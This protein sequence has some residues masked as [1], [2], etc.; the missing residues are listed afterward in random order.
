MLHGQI[1]AMRTTV[2]NGA[3]LAEMWIHSSRVILGMN[4]SGRYFKTL[5]GEV[6]RRVRKIDPGASLELRN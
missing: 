1:V 5:F 4:A 3:T 2:D 6:F